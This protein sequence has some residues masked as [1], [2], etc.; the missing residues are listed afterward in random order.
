LIDIQRVLA[1]P[2][3][4]SGGPRPPPPHRQQYEKLARDGRGPTMR[5]RAGAGTIEKKRDAARVTPIKRR[6]RKRS[7]I[8]S[9]SPIC[10]R[11]RS[12][13]KRMTLAVV[14]WRVGVLCRQRGR[15]HGRGHPRLR[16]GPP[17]QGTEEIG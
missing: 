12:R 17:V 3:R 13:G 10:P 4:G 7:Q 2:A 11:H 6:I 9:V 1:W 16:P 8:S 14:V 15:P 5:R